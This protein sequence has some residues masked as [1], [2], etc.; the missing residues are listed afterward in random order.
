MENHWPVSLETLVPCSG[1]ATKHVTKSCVTQLPY[2]DSEEVSL[3][4]SEVH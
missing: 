4:I 3:E 2:L 1:S